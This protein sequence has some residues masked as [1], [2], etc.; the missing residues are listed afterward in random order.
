[1]ATLPTI[2]AKPLVIPPRPV[3]PPKPKS[4]LEDVTPEQVKERIERILVYAVGGAGKTRFVT[5]LTERFGKAIYIALDEGAENLDSVLP[6]YRDRLIVKRA[7]GPDQMVIGGEIATTNWRAKYPEAK[8]I[9]IDTFTTWAWK[10]LQQITDEA[11]FSEKRITIGEGS[12]LAT[13]LPDKGEYGGV[14]G[15]IRSFI[16]QLFL[17]N[18]DMHIIV[19]CHEDP[20][21]PGVKGGPSTV[22][23]KMTAFLPSRFKTVIHLAS[24]TENVTDKGGVRQVTRPVAWF[25]NHADYIARLNEANI[26]GNPIPSVV[27]PIDP[28]PVWAQYDAAVLAKE[29]A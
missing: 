4:G 28:Q 23:R 12:G 22:G 2:P 20:P 6:Q 9:I 5:S 18:R 17:N 13:T 24:K 1:M 3:A 8:T 26:A 7:V 29:T 14:Q 19:V 10:A 11:Q 21:E 25:S 15:Q 27:V 16:S